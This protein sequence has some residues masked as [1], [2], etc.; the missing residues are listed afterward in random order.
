MQTTLYA[1]PIVFTVGLGLMFAPY[2]SAHVVSCVAFAIA[3]LWAAV[4][5]I[6][7]ARSVKEWAAQQAAQAAGI[8]AFV[9]LVT[10]LMI[11][12]AWPAANA[13][14]A[15]PSVN[16]NCNNFGNNNFN[17]N[18]LNFGP[19][20]QPNGLYQNGRFLGTADRIEVSPD[21]QHVT[22]TVLHLSGIGMDLA[23]NLE[24]QGALIRCPDL[25]SFSKPNT[26]LSLALGGSFKCD[27][28]EQR[29]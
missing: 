29:Q 20:R 13:Q 19:P 11:W 9:L 16:G 12:L 25:A 8:A 4:G 6:M 24:L 28:I 18:T 10:P 23:G 26:N 2:P 1:V 17:C 3:A 21:Q 27:V 15:P 22:L 14:P 5:G 7:W